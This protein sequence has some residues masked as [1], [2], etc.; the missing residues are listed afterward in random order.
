MSKTVFRFFFDFIDGQEKWLNSMAEQ[1]YRLKKCGRLIYTFENCHVSEY[2]YT[3]EYVGNKAHSKALDYQSHLESMGFRT[4]TQSINL[5]RSYGKFRWRPYAEG[6][7]Q[8]ST[9]PGGFNNEIL[10]LE[11]KR[12]G[13]PFDLHTDVSDKL[14][15]YKSVRRTYIWGVLALLALMFITFIPGIM[16][17]PLVGTWILRVLIAVIVVLFSIATVKYFA[18][19]TQLKSESN[20]FE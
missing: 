3:I 9:S 14:M 16:S 18:L 7:G 10:I 1:G 19:A 4:F 6:A 17:L 5:N 2:E 15:A 8:F 13:T 20:I 11:K 12:D